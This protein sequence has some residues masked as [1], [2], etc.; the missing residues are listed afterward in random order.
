[1][2]LELVELLDESVQPRQKLVGPDG[3]RLLFRLGLLPAALQVDRADGV[4]L[5][6]QQLACRTAEL[7]Q[8]VPQGARR[9]AHSGAQRRLRRI[10]VE[11]HLLELRLSL[12]QL[13]E[14]GLRGRAVATRD[15]W[16][17]LNCRLE[18]RRCVGHIFYG[19]ELL[20]ARDP[21]L[22]GGI[23]GH[24]RG[25]GRHRSAMRGGVCW[26]SLASDRTTWDRRRRARRA[27]ASGSASGDR[28]NAALRAALLWHRDHE[29]LALAV[30]RARHVGLREVGVGRKLD[31]AD[32]ALRWQACGPTAHE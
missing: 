14:G 26:S 4:N 3:Q 23:L 15:A 7:S 19:L 24:T 6:F 16:R 25:G 27:R 29:L 31:G 8:A 18:L 12:R 17:R 10:G 22:H 28:L 21:L 32:E 9:S 5:C 20:L 13:R 1:M 11:R 30:W 2:R